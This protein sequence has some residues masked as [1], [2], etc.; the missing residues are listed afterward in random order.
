MIYNLM[1]NPS[2]VLQNVIILE[3]LRDSNLL[4]YGEHLVQLVVGDVVQL[5]AVEFGNDELFQ[6]QLSRLF[7]NAIDVD[8]WRKWTYRVAFAQRS[9]IQERKRLLRFEDLH[10]GDFTCRLS[11][12]LTFF[13]SL[14]LLLFS[15]QA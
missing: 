1:R 5:C 15:T 2:I 14:S 7:L 4:S 10:R 12:A 13:Y 6:R 8:A 3:V 9:N 11:L